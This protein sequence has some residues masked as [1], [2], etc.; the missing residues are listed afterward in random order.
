MLGP[1]SKKHIYYKILHHEIHFY[2]FDCLS[3]FD[4]SYKKLQIN[5]IGTLIMRPNAPDHLLLHSGVLN[6]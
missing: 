4:S 6:L 1:N 3:L 5:K 2:A